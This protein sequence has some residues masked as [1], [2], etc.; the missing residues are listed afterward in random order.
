MNAGLSRGQVGSMVFRFSPLLGYSVDSVLKPKLDFLVN[1]MGK[2]VTEIVDYPRYFS[3]SLEKRIEPRFRLLRSRHVDC[4]L[5][6]MLSKND[7]EFAIDFLGITTLLLPPPS[8]SPAT[9]E[10]VGR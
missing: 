6:E 2:P 4:S 7:D 8:S 10:D 9:E 3:Y 1:A 5:Q